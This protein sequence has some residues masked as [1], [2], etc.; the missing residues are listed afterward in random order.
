MSMGLHRI[1]DDVKTRLNIDHTITDCVSRPQNYTINDLLEL[2]MKLFLDYSNQLIDSIRRDLKKLRLVPTQK[3]WKN[4]NDYIKI[5]KQLSANPRINDIQIKAAEELYNNLVVEKGELDAA[6]P[7]F[8]ILKK[9]TFLYY[10]V[11]IESAVTVGY[12]A[13]INFFYKLLDLNV[14]IGFFV[15]LYAF[16]WLLKKYFDL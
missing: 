15:I 10:L 7:D 8:E 2:N 11:P 6:K 1:Q 5:H 3:Y 16:Y 13:V 9:K 14:V 4:L 12:F